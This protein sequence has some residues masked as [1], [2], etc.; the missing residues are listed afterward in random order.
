MLPELAERLESHARLGS[1]TPELGSMRGESEPSR[2]L[3]P[4]AGR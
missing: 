2:L 1:D 3:L 4:A